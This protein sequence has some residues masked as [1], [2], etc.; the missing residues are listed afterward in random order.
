MKLFAFL[1][2]ALITSIV[3]AIGILGTAICFLIYSAS[4]LNPAFLPYLIGFI[5][6]W[7]GA[8]TLSKALTRVS[9]NY[10]TVHGS[11]G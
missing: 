8:F 3:W 11:A 6:L 1:G 10:G 5:A 7:A 2:A 4:S 9:F